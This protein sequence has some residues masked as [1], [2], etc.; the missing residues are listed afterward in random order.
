M[1]RRKA[2]AR[3]TAPTSSH[4]DRRVTP[5]YHQVYVALRN[6]IQQ[7][8]YPP[9]RPL[10]GEHQLAEEY[11]VSRVTIRHTLKNLEIDGFVARKRGIGTFPLAQRVDLPDRY[12]ISGM[13]E[14]GKFRDA[15]AKVKT[16]SMRQVECPPHIAIQ[17]GSEAPVMRLQRLRSVKREPFT[18]LTVYLPLTI[19]EQLSKAQ[20]RKDPALL[21]MERNGYLMMRADQSITAIAADDVSAPLLKAPV[22]APLIAMSA[23]FSGKDDEPLAVLEGL[24]RP[25]LYEYQ[26]SAIREGSGSNSRWVPLT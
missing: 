21:V 1:A 3:K 2:S 5:L 4:T 17:F 7:G 16:L 11:G 26:T 12:N 13:L 6:K 8:D 23:L 9:E 14:P 22:G 25:E 19:A 18:I 10:P 24:F 15:P 20:L